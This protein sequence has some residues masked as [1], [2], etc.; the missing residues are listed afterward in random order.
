M[1]ID[2]KKGVSAVIAVILMVAITVVL[3]GVLYAWTM[4]MTKPES[5]D[6]IV[7]SVKKQDKGGAFREMEVAGVQGGSIDIPAV[8][9]KVIRNGHVSS[10]ANFSEANVTCETYTTIYSVDTDGDHSPDF[11]IHDNDND[12]KL[13][14]GD[15][16]RIRLSLITTGD[17]VD[18]QFGYT[19]IRL[20]KY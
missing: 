3:T 15:V 8:I 13:T 14:K 20:T 16:I 18:L 12:S 2:S 6:S 5:T 11:Y 1:R 7:I 9:L 19:T 10:Q 4:Q 17:T